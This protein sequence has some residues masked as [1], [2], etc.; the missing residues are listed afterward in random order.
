MANTGNLYTS[1]V[2]SAGTWSNFTTTR[3]NTSDNSYASAVGTTYSTGVLGDFNISIPSEA[4]ILGISLSLEFSAGNAS[5]T[6][7]IRA[8]LSG[9]AGGVYASPLEYSV[10]GTTD[11][12]ILYGGDTDLWGDTWTPSEFSNSNFRIRLSGKTNNAA[13]ACRLDQVTLVIY[14]SV[15]SANFFQF[16][17]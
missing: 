17:N 2:Y 15:Q 11:Q 13:G 14:Y 12:V 4:T 7:Y 10:T 9:D 6:G 3:L 5:H 1:T 8:E 16:F